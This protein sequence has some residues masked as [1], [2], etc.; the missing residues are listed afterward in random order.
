MGEGGREGEEGQRESEG[1]RFTLQENSPS[2]CMMTI[3]ETVKSRC[4]VTL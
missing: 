2:G 3:L 4:K 1:I